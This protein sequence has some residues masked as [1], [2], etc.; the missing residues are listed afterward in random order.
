MRVLIAIA[1]LALSIGCTNFEVAGE[2]EVVTATRNPSIAIPD[3]T[4]DG[5]IDIAQIERS[6]TIDSIEIDI[7][8]RHQFRGDV[9]L[10]LTSADGTL[11]ILKNTE[12]NDEAMDVVGTFP[13]TL[14]P[15]QPL[16]AF[17]GE[18]GQGAW[19]LEAGDLGE[20]DTGTL[21]AWTIRLFCM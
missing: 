4:A 2:L 19:K 5:I 3:D 11:L 18:Q 9:F 20:G 12:D 21:E 6:C 1:A 14:E 16:D 17:A 10:E 15:L 7:E 13:T 8:I